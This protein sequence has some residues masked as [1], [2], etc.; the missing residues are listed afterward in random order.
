M[1]GGVVRVRARL[2][3]LV[4]EGVSKWILEYLLTKLRVGKSSLDS[5]RGW[6]RLGLPPPRDDV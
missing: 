4:C 6:R 2:E 3:I 1:S 5:I